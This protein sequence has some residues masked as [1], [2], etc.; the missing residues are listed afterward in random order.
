MLHIA[1]D[2][3]N[4]NQQQA[5]QQWEQYWIWTNE[6]SVWKGAAIDAVD[7]GVCYRLWLF[8]VRSM[9]QKTFTFASHDISTEHGAQ[10]AHAKH[11][12][13]TVRK[14]DSQSRRYT[15]ASEQTNASGASCRLASP[16]L[17]V[18]LHY[19][20]SCLPPAKAT[21]RVNSKRVCVRVQLWCC[22]YAAKQ[23]TVSGTFGLI[24]S[25]AFRLLAKRKLLCHFVLLSCEES[26]F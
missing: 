4:N 3:N 18:P 11:S 13:V 7:G 9:P 12:D 6:R 1:K 5:Q 22:K 23:H 17:E 10:S 8:V 21:A 15:Q 25:Y 24:G 26:N 2:N 14:A 16:R 20:K 19:R